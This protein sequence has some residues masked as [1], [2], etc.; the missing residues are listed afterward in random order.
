MLYIFL[1]PLTHLQWITVPSPLSKVNSDFYPLTM[2][3]SS[4]WIFGYTYVIVWFTYDVTVGLGIP[5]S[6]LPMLLYPFCVA[7]RES[8]KFKDFIMAL[9]VFDK[10]LQDQ[11]LSLAETYQPQIFQMTFLAGIAWLIYSST[12]G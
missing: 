3:L 10:E 9:E 1:M 11:E 4:A 2:I 7:I 6:I 12:S 5:F 8:K